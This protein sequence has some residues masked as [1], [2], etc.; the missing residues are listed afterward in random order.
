[1]R[2]SYRFCI[3]LSTS[4]LISPANA[5]TGS[6]DLPELK[7][8]S[9]IIKTHDRKPQV[10][11]FNPKACF[12]IKEIRIEGIEVIDPEALKRKVE[13]LAFHCLDNALAN[14]IVLAVNEAHS[15]KGFV[16]TQGALP[17]Q[18]IRQS[19]TLTIN[20][21][22]GKIG[23]VIY[24][25]PETDEDLSF[26]KRIDKR[27]NETKEAKGIW[28]KVKGVSDL[29]DTLD[30]PLDRFQLLDGRR[31]NGLKPWGTFDLEPG[32]TLL[33]ENVQRNADLMNRVTSNK[34]EAK[35]AAGE[36]P[37]TSDVVFT[38]PRNDSFRFLVGYE[39]NG[40]ALN[41]TGSTVD[42]R[43][44]F[45]MA[46]D[47][48]IGINDAW[49]GTFAGGINTN[50]ATLSFSAPWRRFTFGVN[51]S[52]SESLSEITQGVELFERKGIVTGSLGFA[53]EK[54]KSVQS[55]LDSSLTWRKSDRHINGNALTDQT[56]SVLRVGFSRQHH[57]DMTQVYYGAGFNRG[58]SI[59]DALKDPPQPG[60]DIPRAQFWKI[61]G[62][63]GFVHGFK[64]IGTFRVDANGQWA[65][66]PLYGDDQLTL[67]SST[68]VRGFTN[69][70]AKVDRGGVIRSEFAF[71]LP[72]DWIF[73]DKK[74][75][76]LFGYEVLGSLQPYIFADYGFGRQ[77]ADNRDL[78]RSGIGAGVRY[79][80][81]RLN[82]DFSYAHPVYETG[83]HNEDKGP[84]IYLTA[85]VKLF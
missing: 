69:F 66:D 80:H 61:D 2:A 85:S 30:D 40:A 17:D 8:K 43:V 81:G 29:L 42:K 73:G 77:L 36:K 76:L 26:S 4:F 23:K 3:L 39:T 83:L 72:K 75:D 71:A 20:V 7:G 82:I 18:D 52:Y 49:R 10:K 32:D 19:G 47:N 64:G 21:Y 56:F 45:D 38:N 33:I 9:L 63:L 84:E 59:F 55:S 11:D 27:W 53:L 57:F 5:E 78:A 50:E 68:S 46:K 14:A 60:G 74:D 65:D 79:Q 44:R 12:P 24:R 25:E 62:S 35:L 54:T 41:N 31:F 58:L 22:T 28:N 34:A 51:G 15:D 70:A 37:G 13:P 67:G 48:L 16:T 6:K 1:M